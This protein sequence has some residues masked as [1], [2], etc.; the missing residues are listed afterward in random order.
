MREIRMHIVLQYVSLW[1]GK[2]DV[3]DDNGQWLTT[4]GHVRSGVWLCSAKCPGSV[5]T[6][7]MAEYESGSVMERD[8]PHHV[9]YPMIGGEEAPSW[10][11]PVFGVPV[12]LIWLF[13]TE[14]W[15]GNGIWMT[16]LS[17]LLSQIFNT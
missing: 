3:L 2:T 9:L 12:E 10:F 15:I 6:T 1:L 11:E 5:W 13:W 8:I 14:I 4:A 17:Q 16:F 7:M